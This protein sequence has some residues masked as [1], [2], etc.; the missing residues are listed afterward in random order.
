MKKCKLSDVVSALVAVFAFGACST[1]GACSAL[2]DNGIS[3]DGWDG[4]YGWNAGDGDESEIDHRHPVFD[5][6]GTD[7]RFYVGAEGC[8][9]EGEA[10]FEDYSEDGGATTRPILT[11]LQNS[12]IAFVINA[13]YAADVRLMVRLAVDTG[14]N[15]DGS[16]RVIWA[17]DKFAL[18]VNGQEH[19][20]DAQDG[21]NEKW[22]W[23]PH[24]SWWI[25]ANYIDASFG[26]VHLSSGNNTFILTTKSGNIQLDCFMLDKIQ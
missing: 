9:Y 18:T 11:Q 4:W 3:G 2:G 13:A 23:Q 26:T 8:Y 21:V 5:Y 1:L 22:L 17:S 25:N 20:L 15:A 16:R 24:E 19:N 10:I 7:D 14:T 12:T 6:D